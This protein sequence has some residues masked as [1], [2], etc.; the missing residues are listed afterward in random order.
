MSEWL[1]N[2]QG[3]FVRRGLWGELLFFLH[4]RAGVD[5]ALVIHFIVLVSVCTLVCVVVRM[6]Y[7][8]G[9]SCFLL[10]FVF[11][12]GGLWAPAWTLME[13][14]RDALMLTLA[15]AAFWFYGKWLKNN[16][17]GSVIAIWMI[18]CFAILSH[19]PSFFI[20]FP[21]MGAHLFLHQLQRHSFWA[22]ARRVAQAARAEQ[23]TA[24]AASP[25]GG[26]WN[27]T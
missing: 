18:G 21:F 19:E 27:G 8:N 4:R 25:G 14:R 2:Y 26:S 11:M 15:A 6:F 16:S 22:A 13:G 1:I 12:L 5:P 7:K 24:M 9:Y 20:V 23:A 10:P 17:F 3:G